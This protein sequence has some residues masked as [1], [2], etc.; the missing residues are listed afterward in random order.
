MTFGPFQPFYDSLIL[1]QKLGL[2]RK[3]NAKLS[4]VY[5]QPCTGSAQAYAAP[6]K[7]AG[8][9]LLQFPTE[10]IP[11]ASPHPLERYATSPA[12]GAAA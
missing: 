4:Q 10:L 11:G 1:P 6:K 7:A 5:T 9:R 12:P 3:D 2:L 8:G